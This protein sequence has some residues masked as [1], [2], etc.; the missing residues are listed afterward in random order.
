MKTIKEKIEE[1]ALKYKRESGFSRDEDAFQ[2]GADFAIKAVIEMLEER[3]S[4]L[5]KER[6]KSFDRDTKASIA[7]KIRSI[8]EIINLLKSE[9]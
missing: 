2:D 9:A 3:R 1:A 6:Y 8:N 5:S 7:C 4:R